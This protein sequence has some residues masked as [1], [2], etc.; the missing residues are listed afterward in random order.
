MLVPGFVNLVC[1]CIVFHKSLLS[2][3]SQE[4][5]ISKSW[6][7]SFSI[8]LNE[9]PTV[10]F[11]GIHRFVGLFRMNQQ[12]THSKV[13]RRKDTLEFSKADFWHFANSVDRRT[14]T[15]L[16][17]EENVCDTLGLVRVDLS[18]SLG[19]VRVDLVGSKTKTGDWHLF[20]VPWNGR[21]R[22]PDRGVL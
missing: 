2:K 13:Y 5:Q 7:S 18:W 12:E 22:R 11:G 8:L 15:T 20:L 16:I 19:P 4:T 14:V 10:S 1:R 6:W 9:F 21:G 3:N 17:V